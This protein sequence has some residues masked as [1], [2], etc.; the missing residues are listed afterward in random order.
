[1]T[2]AADITLFYSDKIRKY[3][4]F[5]QWYPASFL[6][7]GVKYKNAE[8]YMMG[9][10]ALVFDD[11]VVYEKIIAASDPRRI[12]ALGRKVKNFDEE[13]WDTTKL[14]VVVYGNR[15][16]FSQNPQLADILL[17]TGDSIIA[18]ASPYDKV[19]GIGLKHNDKAAM[20]PELWCSKN[21]TKFKGENLLGKAL[22]EIRKELKE[23]LKK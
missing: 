23:K 8:Q 17:S 15:E 16:K 5:S 6:V 22:M 9:E 21:R 19:W 2:T 13:L 1:M 7:D 4:C 20:I 3:A 10:K 12:K 18:E 14:E 11:Y